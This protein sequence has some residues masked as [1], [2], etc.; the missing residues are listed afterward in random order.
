[1]SEKTNTKRANRR[2]KD[3]TSDEDEVLADG[4]EEGLSDE[5]LAAVL[6]RSA[7]AVSLRRTRLANN[8][9]KTAK[10]RSIS[11]AR[12][13]RRVVKRRKQAAQDEKIQEAAAKL[14]KKSIPERKVHDG[15]AA[16]A[17]MFTQ[18]KVITYDPASIAVP[19]LQVTVT[20]EPE[21]RLSVPQQD[22]S[23]QLILISFI[24]GLATGTSL[25]AV[26]GGYL[27]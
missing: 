27:Q 13:I 16:Q 9:V 20:P 6:D 24:A 22:S 14:V 23:L 10:G 18:P 12:K 2:I 4:F 3:W 1:M 11:A 17:E 25:I 7:K 15:L 21:E 19:D 26:I 5:A 8:K